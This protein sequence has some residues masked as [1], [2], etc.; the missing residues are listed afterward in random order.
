MTQLTQAAQSCKGHPMNRF[1][2][3]PSDDPCVEDD[4]YTVVGGN[5][6]VSIQVAAYAGGYAVNSYGE[7][8]VGDP[9]TFYME[10]HGIYRSLAAAKAK[11][12]EVAD[13]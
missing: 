9:S 4:S 5:R 6:E 13:A 1:I 2:F 3:T 7:E 11:A 10:D 8:T 12:L